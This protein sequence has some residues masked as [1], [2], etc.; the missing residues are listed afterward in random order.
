MQNQD[1]IVGNYAWRVSSLGKRVI[2]TLLSPDR[3]SRKGPSK[4]VTLLTLPKA[5]KQ[6]GSS[7]CLKTPLSMSNIMLP[8]RQGQD[9]GADLYS[10]PNNPYPTARFRNYV[11]LE[12]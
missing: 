9:N 12:G 1:G 5:K 11:N 3:R 4:D 8:D 10:I 7:E 6:L 2:N